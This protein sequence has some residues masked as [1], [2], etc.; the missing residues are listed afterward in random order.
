MF[1]TIQL[2]DLTN[3]ESVQLVSVF[4]SVL[5]VSYSFTTHYRRKKS[6][7]MGSFQLGTALYFL[8]TLCLVVSRLLA[9][10]LFAY[11]FPPGKW[12]YA[13]SAVVYHVV[14]MAVMHGVMMRQSLF[15]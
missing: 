2:A 10:V 3:T 5:S 9:F 4:F 7:A 8:H 15:K 11:Y 14:V 13:A 12:H 6:E 1:L